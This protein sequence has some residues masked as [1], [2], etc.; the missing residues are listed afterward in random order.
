MPVALAT[1]ATDRSI[2]PHRI[3]KVSPDRHDA[4]DGD[5]SQD[6]GEVVAG[7]EGGAGKGEEHARGTSSVANG[8][9]LRIWLR[10][11]MRSVP[12]RGARALVA[13][14]PDRTRCHL[15]PHAAS[16]K[17]VLADRR[18]RRIRGRSRPFFMTRMR[19]AR[20]STVSGSVDTTTMANS[21]GRAGRARCAPRRPWPRHP[22]RVS[23]RSAP[24]PWADRSAIWRA[25]PSAGCRPTASPE[26]RIGIG[27]ADVERGDLPAGE[28]PARCRA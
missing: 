6:I 25:P 17:L 22:C 26:R 20:D 24:A 13:A 1:A 2:S 14:R 18:L 11:Q 7:G 28:R 21:P 8:A 23:A 15:I 19:S 27:R 9:T 10:S 4:G 12:A 16:S 3:T 5:L